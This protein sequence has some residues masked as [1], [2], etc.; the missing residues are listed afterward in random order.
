VHNFI[1]AC[2]VAAAVHSK[3]VKVVAQALSALAGVKAAQ[4]TSK[5]TLEL[6]WHTVAVMVSHSILF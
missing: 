1:S 4:I 3:D 2:A 5:E 6:M